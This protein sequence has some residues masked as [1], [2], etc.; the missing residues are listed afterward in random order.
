MIGDAEIKMMQIRV[1]NEKVIQQM[2][3]DI[4]Q[5]QSQF[6]PLSNGLYETLDYIRLNLELQK[7]HGI[8]VIMTR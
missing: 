2:I 1:K 5:I 8:E 6:Q 3:N 4:K 7:Q